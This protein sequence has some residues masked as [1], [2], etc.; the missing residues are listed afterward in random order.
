M[1]WFYRVWVIVCLLVIVGQ[2][3]F[4]HEAVHSAVCLGVG[5]DVSFSVDFLSVSTW[6]SY[7]S[8]SM[9]D[10]DFLNSVNELVG[11]SLSAVLGVLL[12]YPFYLSGVKKV[13][14]GS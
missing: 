7:K 8:G 14:E 3:V 2:F 4:W 9:S 13:L 5:G 1:S 6:C 11:Y 10:L 12:L